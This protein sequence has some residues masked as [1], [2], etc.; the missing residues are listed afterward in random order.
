MVLLSL[1]L[2]LG[3]ARVGLAALG[4]GSC[5]FTAING[6]GPDSFRLVLLEPMEPGETIKV[7]FRMVDDSGNWVGSS[8][9]NDLSYT[10]SSCQLPGVTLAGVQGTTSGNAFAWA[11]G[12]E[13][14]SNGGDTLIAVSADDTPLCAA[15]TE[16]DT[17]GFV[18]GAQT[19]L[20]A[21]LTANSADAITKGPVVSM[22]YQGV[23]SGTLADVK[24]AIV[25]L[26]SNWLVN[27]AGNYVSCTSPATSFTLSDA[28]TQMWSVRG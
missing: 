3:W 22:C 26:G 2:A 6:Q 19:A 18:N 9:S 21:G 23:T 14:L 8:S 16:A 24:A 15:S 10:A 7:T 5:A 13:Q 1:A 17:W 20:P 27:L 25:N 11:N 4:P 12:G 28:A